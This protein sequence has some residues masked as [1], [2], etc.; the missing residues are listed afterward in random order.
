MRAFLSEADT[1]SEIRKYCRKAKRIR[2]A[3]ALITGSGLKLIEADLE[4]LL[5]RGGEIQVLVGTDMATD[6]EAIEAL[7]KLQE[8]YSDQMTIRRFASDSSQIFHP[9]V[10]T[11]SFRAGPGAAIVGSSNLSLGGLGCNLEANVLVDGGGVVGEL[12]GFFDELFEGG[13]AKQI[14]TMWLDSYRELWKQ[15][16]AARMKLDRLQKK[17]KFIRT[18][19][20]VRATVPSRIRKHSFAFTGRIAGWPRESTLYPIIEQYGG[21]VNEFEGLNKAEC[22]VH[23]DIRGGTQTTRKLRAARRDGIDIISQSDF[24]R[25][26]DNEKR[27]RK[28]NRPARS[29]RR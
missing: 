29:T 3:L 15:Q 18:R 27:L 6:P 28:R 5:A 12:K 16:R 19:P 20:A 22:L 14:D 17:A 25:I 24:F 8:Q 10:W 9:K 21:N 11:F 7:L 23:G 1:L 4:Q 2:T 13:R 26:L